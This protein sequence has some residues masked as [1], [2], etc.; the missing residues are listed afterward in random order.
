MIKSKCPHCGFMISKPL[1]VNETDM[2]SLHLANRLF[3]CPECY[4]EIN[5]KIKYYNYV[6]SIIF[7][8]VAAGI[9]IIGIDNMSLFMAVLAPLL[10]LYILNN[11]AFVKGYKVYNPSTKMYE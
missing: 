3:F 10:V 6:I 9:Y 5:I 1:S 8:I 2:K 11:R 4:K 7:L